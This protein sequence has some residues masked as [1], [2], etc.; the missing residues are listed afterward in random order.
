MEAHMATPR[1]LDQVR[2]AI[3]VRH[4]SRRTE[5]MYVQWIRRFILFHARRYPQEMSERKITAFLI[6]LAVQKNV[7]ASTQNQ[8]LSALLFLYRKVPDI[9]PGW[10]G[11]VIRVRRPQRRPMVLLHGLVR[12]RRAHGLS[13]CVPSSELPQAC[14]TP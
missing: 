11:G 8:A 3:R 12:L 7:A 5:D 4:Y 1:L 6:Y 9:E 13:G 14:Q 2:D 10:L